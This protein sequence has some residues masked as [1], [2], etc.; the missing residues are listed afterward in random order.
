MRP[1]KSIDEIAM[2][3]KASVTRTISEAD[4]LQFA[5]LT[6]DRNPVHI[7]EEYARQ[8]MFGARVAHGSFTT[9]LISGVLGM[10]LPGLGTIAYE[11]RCRF[12]Y[13]V[14]FGDTI[15]ATV[16]VVEKNQAKNLVKFKCSWTNQSGVVVAD[17]EAVVIPPRKDS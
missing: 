5:D 2:G 14:Y 16:E 11:S 15:T 3:E 6:G 4:V 10:Q 7:D 12:R 8:S 13:P 9:A 1:G 17:G